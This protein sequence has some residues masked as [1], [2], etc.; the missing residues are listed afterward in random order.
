MQERN[1]RIMRKILESPY[2]LASNYTAVQARGTNLTI[3]APHSSTDEDNFITLQKSYRSC[4]DTDAIRQAGISPVLDILRNLNQIWQFSPNDLAAPLNASDLDAF[5]QALTY[6]HTLGVSTFQSVTIQIDPASPDSNAI[7]VDVPALSS[8]NTTVYEDVA[9]L[10]EFARSV[11][12]SLAGFLPPGVSA[13][14]ASTLAN[15][16]AILESRLHQAEKAARSAPVQPSGSGDDPVWA[17]FGYH[18]M[19][20]ANASALAP[21]LGLD[22]LIHSLAPSNYTTDKVIVSSPG[23]MSNVS[24]VIGTTPKAFIQTL[25][26]WR[27]LS[28]F[29][30]YLDAPILGS[31]INDDKRWQTC[32]KEMDTSLRWIMGRFYL[33][34][35]FKERSRTLA[36]GM[37]KDIR[38]QFIQRIGALDWLSPQVKELAIQ[39]VNN[40][41]Q[42]IGYPTADPDIHDPEDLAKYYRGLNVS[43]AY[44]ANAV[45]YAQ[46]ENARQWSSLA[47]PADRESFLFPL[48]TVNAVNFVYN[49]IQIL[50]GIMQMPIFSPDLPSYATYGGLGVILGH[51]LTHGFDNKGRDFNQDGAL[52][53]WWDAQSTAGFTNRSQCFV[54]QY[55]SLTVPTPGGPMQVDGQKT[56]GENIADAGG[57]NTAYAAWKAK[58]GAVH[59]QSLPGLQD[60][61]PDQLFYLFFGYTWCSSYTPKSNLE[62]LKTDIHAPDPTRILGTAANSRGF[63]QAFNCPVKEPTCELW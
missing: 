45:S 59:E 10:E 7:I 60:F 40:I 54:E 32:V 48:D 22:K 4:M 6:L 53:T 38:Q 3:T 14:V 47:R 55:N 5:S 50:P 30:T 51:E 31:Q 24:D 25:L 43:N 1:Y 34:A 58:V 35:N 21:A 27:T 57:V 46:W 36:D 26:V 16:M 41:R 15:G 28:K 33:S 61:T 42:D 12:A 18:P 56:L 62:S 20:V 44:F 11:A 63:R 49:T 37:L 29:K 52:R 23:F 17:S 2:P 39:K 19:T 13:G 9:A 8:D